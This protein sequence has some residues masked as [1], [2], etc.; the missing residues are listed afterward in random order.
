MSTDTASAGIELRHGRWRT[1]VLPQLGGSLA[2]LEFERDGRWQPLLRPTPAGAEDPRQTACFPMAPFCG[3]IRDGRFVFRGR[4]VTLPATPPETRTPLHGLVWR[5]PWQIV[6]RHAASLL[7]QCAYPKG[8]WPWP[9]IATQAFCLDDAGLSVEL[10]LRN[11][12]SQ[13]LPCGLGLH[14]YFPCDSGTRVSARLARRVRCDAMQIPIYHEACAG[15]AQDPIHQLGLD[16]SFDGWDGTL[17]ADNTAVMRANA[18][19]LHVYA[20]TGEDYFCAEPMSHEVNALA[21]DEDA[22]LAAGLQLLAPGASTRL[23]ARFE[24]P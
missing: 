4:A 17:H 11:T 21:L 7:I 20:P 12:G 24:S 9:F 18:T 1:A 10:L 16:D 5:L 14:P 8:D 6:E 2:S 13:T 15:F 23:H 22:A 19:R 3:R